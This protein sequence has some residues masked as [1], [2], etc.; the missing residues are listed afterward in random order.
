MA[1]VVKYLFRLSTGE[2]LYIGDY[3]NGKIYELDLAT[4]TDNS[5]E[6]RRVRRTQHTHSDGRDIICNEIEIDFEM[7]VGI[8]GSTG[9]PG[10]DP[11]AMLRWSNDGG[12]TF[13][14]EHWRSMGK[15]GEYSKRARWRRCGRYKDRVYELVISDP[16]KVS[17]IKAYADLEVVE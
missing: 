11:Q 16:V 8:A 6:I 17:I 5:E 9:T 7:G 15:I 10:V 1:D 4:Y 2:S 3:N 12:H 14:N 13:K